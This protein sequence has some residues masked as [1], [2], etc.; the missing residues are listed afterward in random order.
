MLCEFRG[1][2]IG[3][4]LYILDLRRQIAAAVNMAAGKGTEDISAYTNAELI[5]CNIENI[6]VMRTSLSC[7]GDAIAAGAEGDLSFG[8][9]VEESGWLRHLS[10]LL[11]ASVLAA[12]KLHLEAA[13][14][15]CHC[16]DG[17]DRTSQMC[18]L[19]QLML[20][21]YYRTIEGFA[22]LIEKDWG[23]FGHKFKDRCGHGLDYNVAGDERSPIFLQFLDAVFQMTIQFPS[24][25]EFTSQLLVFLADHCTSGLFGNFIG[26]SYRQRHNELNVQDN[27]KNVWAVVFQRKEVFLDARY[28]L[29]PHPI[30]PASSLKKLI[31]WERYFLRWDPT[32][33][34]S[35]IDGEWKDMW[36]DLF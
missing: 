32:C 20:D 35:G 17:F 36:D 22:V 27:T 8:S 11:A 33:H 21:P 4:K 6:H 19:T 16:S 24:A 25:F 1:A 14:V 9:K 10:L 3:P 13:T 34:P 30:W 18:A 7:L 31:L 5:F 28:T 26:N 12:E 23:A 29:C 2:F 15:L